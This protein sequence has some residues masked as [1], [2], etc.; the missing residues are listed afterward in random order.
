MVGHQ[1]VGAL[2]GDY[3]G[4]NVVEVSIFAFEEGNSLAWTLKD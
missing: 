1:T 4:M 3:R 2:P